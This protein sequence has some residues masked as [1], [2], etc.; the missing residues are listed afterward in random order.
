MENFKTLTH[1]Q[2]LGVLCLMSIS[3]WFLFALVFRLYW[4]TSLPIEE[5][6]VL[7]WMWL[8]VASLVFVVSLY[9]IF[10]LFNISPRNRPSAGIALTAPAMCLDVFTTQFIEVW[11]PSAGA[12]DDRHY[13]ALIIGGVAIILLVCLASSGER[14]K[15]ESA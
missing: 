2:T 3:F 12:F 13:A 10:W 4:Q 6:R 11:L 8:I 7:F 5:Q 1:K 14:H 15:S 9:S